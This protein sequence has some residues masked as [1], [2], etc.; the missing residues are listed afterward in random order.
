[1]VDALSDSLAVAGSGEGWYADPWKQA[2]MRW[3]DGL[4][5]TSHTGSGPK[6]C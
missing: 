4:Q 2:P 3:W 5:W 6:A 1:M